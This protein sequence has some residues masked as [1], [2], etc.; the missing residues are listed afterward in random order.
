MTKAACDR[1]AASVAIGDGRD[2]GRGGGERGAGRPARGD[3][4]GGDSYE[5]QGV[6]RARRARRVA[7][8]ASAALC[9]VAA[10][11]GVMLGSTPVALSDVAAV[12]TGGAPSSPAIGNIVQH[13]RLPRVLAALLAGAALA[14]S[15]S[16][17]QTVLNNPLASPNVLGINS[18]AG[19]CVLMASA[20]APGV[21]GVLPFAAFAG[22][23]ACA[24]LVFAVAARGDGSRVTIVLVGMAATAVFG[25]GMNAVLIVQ[26]DAYVGAG[27]FL[28]GGLSGV[29]MVDLSWPSLP[30][31]AGLALAVLGSRAL[32]V[33]AAG[34]TVAQSVGMNVRAVRLGMLAVA[35]LLAGAAVSFAGLLGFVGLVV[36]HIVRLATGND[37]VYLVPTS[38]FAGAGFV[39][40]CDILARTLFAPY[41][42]PVGILMAFVGGPFFV[43]LVARK[44]GERRG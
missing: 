15:G 41:E 26:P 43:W 40:L 25:A 13:V 3:A 33:I 22:A 5:A 16:V 8:A 2:G 1:G 36:P 9:L 31:L 27:T 7:L 39:C 29:R 35:A 42:L 4:R 24:L 17:I 20:L 19:L 32:N 18:G 10:A 23:L 38:A 11:L 28:V 12:L 6:A 30:I 44:G 14:V 37:L 21:L 34:D